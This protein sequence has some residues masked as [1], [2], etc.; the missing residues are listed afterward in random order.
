[1]EWASNPRHTVIFTDRP[2]PGTLAHQLLTMAP[3]VLELEVTY[4]LLSP[5]NLSSIL[6]LALQQQLHR[7]VPLE[8]SELRE[9]RTKQQEERM[10]KLLEEQKKVSLSS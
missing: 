8:G 6:N 5:Q 9:W 3:R 10:Q 1:V 7:C 2:Q 4:Y